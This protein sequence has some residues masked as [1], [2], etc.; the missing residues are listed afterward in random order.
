ML[1]KNL[2]NN[3]CSF[4]SSADEEEFIFIFNGRIYQHLWHKFVDIYDRDVIAFY[5]SLDTDNRIL[6]EYYIEAL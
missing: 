2:L 5:N 4:R 3:L 1:V 6:F